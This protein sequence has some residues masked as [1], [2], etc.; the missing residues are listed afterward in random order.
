MENP[1]VATLLGSLS[2]WR[3]PALGGVE[4]DGHEG[5][6]QPHRSMAV[7]FCESFNTCLPSVRAHGWLGL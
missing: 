5:P 1:T 3:H 7:W 6:F 2:W 4:L